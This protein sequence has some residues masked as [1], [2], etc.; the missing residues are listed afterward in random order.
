MNG[1]LSFEEASTALFGR[2]TRTERNRLNK[3]INQG[4]ISAIRDER[5]TWFPRAEIKR[6]IGEKDETDLSQ[7]PR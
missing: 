4:Y 6:L 3:W 1:L 5:R 7:M 2:A